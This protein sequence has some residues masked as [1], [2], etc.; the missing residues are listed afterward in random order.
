MHS[1]GIKKR[2]ISHP[3]LQ[4]NYEL[5]LILNQRR[6]RC[7]NP[8]CLYET[9]ESFKFVNRSRRCT[10]ASD[11]LIVMAFKDLSASASAIARQ[12]HTS[13]TH[14]L[15]VCKRQV[16]FLKKRHLFFL[17]CGKLFSRVCGILF[18]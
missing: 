4:D 18:S 2:K 3:I 15:E 6:W 8:E 17:K 12:F 9:N 10:N 7:T 13:D 1:R 11:M 5:I 16:L 14:V